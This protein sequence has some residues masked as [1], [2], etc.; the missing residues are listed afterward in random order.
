MER[1][2]ASGFEPIEV[3][4]ALVHPMYER[5]IEEGD[6]VRMT[7]VSAASPRVQ[8]IVLSLRIP[9]RKGRKGEGG[10]LRIAGVEAPEMALWMDRA[11]PVVD[12][13]CIKSKRGAELWVTNQWRHADGVE[14]EMLNNFGMRIEELG[15]RSVLLHCSDGYG[16]APSFDDL[17]VQIDV[18]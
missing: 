5:A 12:A 11:P 9:G 17:V 10:L 3:D 8:G 14:E 13:E 2:A 1:F 18:V 15:P 16:D 7:W 6:R 4:G